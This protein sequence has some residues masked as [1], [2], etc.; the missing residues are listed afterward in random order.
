MTCDSCEAELPAFCDYED[1]RGEWDEDH[2]FVTAVY[3]IFICPEC[4]TEH[5][6]HIGDRPSTSVGGSR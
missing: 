1:R 6:V 3:E 5:R 2:G 4:S